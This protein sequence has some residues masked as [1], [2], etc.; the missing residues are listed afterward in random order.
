MSIPLKAT[1]KCNNKPEKSQYNIQKS[2]DHHGDLLGNKNKGVLRIYQQNIRGAKLYNSWEKWKEGVR[3]LNNKQIDIAFT[4]ETNTNWTTKNISAAKAKAKAVSH[5]VLFEGSSSTE[6]KDTDY[7][8]GGSACLIINNLTGYKKETINDKK[9]LGR[10]CGFKL[11]GL[12][13]KTIVV[14][15]AYRPTVSKDVCDNTC[16]SQQ[17]RILRKTSNVE[18]NPRENFMIDLKNMVKEWEQEQSEII[19]GVDMNE[20]INTR[21]S[22]VSLLLENTTLV[23]LLETD[24]APATYN[25]GKNCIDFILGTPNIK[26]KI[27]AQGYLPF[28]SGGWESD[29]RG[30]FVDID[31]NNLFNQIDTD[32]SYIGRNLDSSNWLQATKFMNKL[33]LEKLKHI[34]KEM[35]KIELLQF[36]NKQQVDT[37]EAL[38]TDFTEILISSE[39]KCKTTTNHWSDTLRHA[40]LINK[41]WRIQSKGKLN[42]IK[43][44]KILKDIELNLP[45]AE[46]IWQGDISRSPKCQLQRSIKSV[47]K[48]K[49]ES[50]EHRKEYL[51]RLNY[52]Y[53]EMGEEKKAQAI[54]KIRKAEFKLRCQKICKL[55][56]KPR[57]DSGGLTH[58]LI[59]KDNSEEIIDSSKDIEKLLINR[60]IEHFAQAHNTPCASGEM[61]RL[62]GNDGLT[63]SSTKALKGII[64]ENNI[65]QESIDILKELKQVRKTLSEIIPINEMKNGFLTW[66]EKTVT[67]PSGKHLGIYRTLIKW[68]NGKYDNHKT[69]QSTSSTKAENKNNE[70]ADLAIHIQHSLMNMAIKHSYTYQRWKTIHNFFIEKIPGR[71]LINKLRVIHIYEADWNYILKYFV[72]HQLHSRACREETVREEQTG[73]RAGKSAAY[74]ATAAVITNEIICLQK[75][76]CVTIFNDAAACFDRIIENISNLTLMREGLH[77]KVAKLHSQTLASAKYY[78]KTKMGISA[79]PNG[80]NNPAPFYGT[81]QGAA[82]SMPRW[83]ILSD[84]IIRLYINKAKSNNLYSPISK[85]QIQAIIKAYVDDTHSTF[86]GNSINELKFFLIHNAKLWESLLH[87]IGGKLEI[88]KCKFV[89]YN[90]KYDEIGTRKLIREKSIGQITI[91]DSETGKDMQINEIDV[92]EPYKL[93]GI[94]MAP[95][96]NQQGNITSMQERCEKMKKLIKTANLPP[97]EMETCLYSIVLPTLKYGQAAMSIPKETILNVQ[98][99]LINMILPRI[100]YNRHIPRALVYA[101]KKYGGLEIPNLY[102]EQGIAQIKYILGALR[103]NCEASNLITGLMETYNISTGTLSHPFQ[104]KTIIQYVESK[105]INSIIIFLTSIKGKITI[106]NYTGFQKLRINDEAIM[107]AAMKTFNTNTQLQAINNCRI[108]LQIV[109]FA[110]I[111]NLEGTKIHNEAIL[112]SYDTKGRPTIQRYSKSLALW[113]DTTRPPEKAWRIWKKWIRTKMFTKTNILKKPLMRWLPVSKVNRIWYNTANQSI[114][115]DLTPTITNEPPRYNVTDLNTMKRITSVAT[116]K[117]MVNSSITR[118]ECKTVWVLYEQNEIIKI[119]RTKRETTAYQGRER[120][121]LLAIYAALSFILNSHKIIHSKPPPSYITIIS[122]NTTIEKILIKARYEYPTIHSLTGNEADLINE[123]RILLKQFNNYKIKKTMT[124]QTMTDLETTTIF[125]MTRIKNEDIYLQNKNDY[126]PNIELIINNQKITGLMHSAIHHESTKQDYIEYITKKKSWINQQCDYIDWGALEKATKKLTKSK[127]TFVCKYIHGWLPTRGHPGYDT[128]KC[129]NKNCP[130]CKNCIESNSHFL[131]CNWNRKE[132]TSILEKKLKAID[133]KTNI[134]SILTQAIIST[135]NNDKIQLPDN[136]KQLEIR[137]KRIGFDQ[138]LIGRYAT[139]WAEE[140]NRETNTTLGQIWISN[141]IFK[142]WEHQQ[143]RWHERNKIADEEINKN[144]NKCETT[145]NKIKDLYSQQ[146]QLDNIDQQAMAMPLEDRLQTTTSSKIQWIKHTKEIVK[147]GI[148]RNKCKTIKEHRSIRKYFNTEKTGSPPKC[149]EIVLAN[150]T[151]KRRVTKKR[152]KVRKENYYPP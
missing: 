37:L 30:I 88:S 87:Q 16:Y 44:I 108:Y 84:L 139:N 124:K 80:H 71:P 53:K 58:L 73:G 6:H 106:N 150:G 36:L 101:S 34:S 140:Y 56:N 112:G 99:P 96:N 77:P 127:H 67:S 145:D 48:I 33:N 4:V 51:L 9:G 91:K 25:R 62:L 144:N 146:S 41:Y 10:W 21:K 14:L 142:I 120:G 57:G 129:L 122:P 116:I 82:D 42:N 125:N 54:Y 26:Q 141:T 39:K 81:G 86:T 97:K 92:T 38:D 134:Q 121:N 59:E 93:L 8:P 117:L 107:E 102:T 29:H 22:K 137:Q 49:S 109:T 83:C 100:G 94:Q 28:Y 111:T 104:R 85:K 5:S 138:L 64:T 20:P 119:E 72:S 105:W 1:N 50:W 23:S 143:Q 74:S 147:Q 40:R 132:D 66:R 65:Q 46:K 27:I 45:N 136:Y 149:K 63:E 115:T 148:R 55:I 69:H 131:L 98:K 95:A 3:W 152:N 43:V 90:W 15:S 113:P 78:I 35:K 118:E 135:A 68:H 103:S 11:K 18:P 2:N 133:T 70:K 110:E 13:K 52:R 60:N 76:N 114:I 31:I 75:L 17:W 123:I 7:Q 130:L 89:I 128:I 12:N 126:S 19:I 61:H 151:S 24:N 79:K 47:N 32:N